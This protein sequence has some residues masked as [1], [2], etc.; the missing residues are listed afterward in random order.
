MKTTDALAA[1]YEYSAS[2]YRTLNDVQQRVKGAIDAKVATGE[3]EFEHVPCLLCGST[4][5]QSIAQRDRYGLRN[6]VEICQDCGLVF[7]NP[8][9]TQP[10]YLEF[11][12]REYRA[13]YLGTVQNA[14]LAFRDE[15][16]RGQQI[17]AFLNRCG[18][19]QKLPSRPVVLDV[20]CGAGGV[21]SALRE[22]GA[23]VYGA[24]FDRQLLDY[25]REQHALDLLEGD[26]AKLSGSDADLIV[27]SH[28]FEH[29]LDPI[30]EFRRIRDMFSEHVKLFVEVPG[31]KWL[32]RGNYDFLDTIQNAHTCYFTART[33]TRMA[34]CGGFEKLHC[35]EYIRSVF[36]PG[37]GMRQPVG[38]SRNEYRST[39]N[40]LR[41]VELERR[42][43]P[44]PPA[45]FL[46]RCRSWL[47][48]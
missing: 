19:W 33:L 17:F 25:G 11:Y 36:Q 3:Y 46:R 6:T 5:S 9:L 44:I 20:G 39:L 13:L 34:C 10:C 16:Q 29:L 40:Y 12:R 8:R 41:S 7:T 45:K 32:R 43:L 18:I 31:L 30:A 38:I 15:R 47:R 48:R 37:A 27:Y 21:L 22:H 2:P 26:I 1:R 24:D 35:D 42:L 4:N 14:E 23:T 28:V